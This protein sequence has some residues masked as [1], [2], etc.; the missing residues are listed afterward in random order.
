MSEYDSAMF[1][2]AKVKSMWDYRAHLPVDNAA[3]I[4]SL[5]EG[6]TPLLEA[7][8]FGE[9]HVFI[10]NETRNPTGSQKDRGVSVALSKA[11]ELG[12]SRVI[13]A[14]TGSSGFACA[15]Y[16]ARAG[17]PCVILVPADTPSARTAPMAAHGA[18]VVQIQ[19]P[20]TRTADIF[21]AVRA[22]P[23]WYIAATNRQMNPYQGDGTRTMAF[24]IFGELQA[25][26]DWII[27]PV[28]SGGTLSSLWRGF[29]E[30]KRNGVIASIP[31]MV[32]VQPSGY[33]SVEQALARG[34]FDRDGVSKL[35]AEGSGETAMLNLRT[36]RRSDLADAVSAVEGSGGLALSVSDAEASEWQFKI[37]AQEGVF[38]E[39]SGAAGFAGLAKLL[40][41]QIIQRG[42]LSV[43]IATGSGLR[44][45]SAIERPH[46]V[47][48]PDPLTLA[49]LGAFTRQSLPA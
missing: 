37:A 20:F 4:V 35:A 27:V 6:G 40:R 22:D 2:P 17:I 21:E 32:A 36:G 30:L 5:G 31:K 18:I 34:I 33:N 41:D 42:E 25:V 13:T 14:S 19:G 49:D 38:V 11:K 43:V 29:N 1:P 9:Q 47:S 23:S 12:V 28:G 39:P 7:R 10:K 24:E 45:L 46:R 26:P 8:S 16:S 3:N 44:Q 48:A 15:T